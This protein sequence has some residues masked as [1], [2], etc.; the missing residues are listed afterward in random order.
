MTRLLSKGSVV[1]RSHY[2]VED[3]L[4]VRLRRL[5]YEIVGTN[6][7]PLLF[8]SSSLELIVMTETAGDG[9]L[10]LAAFTLRAPLRDEEGAPS[11]PDWDWGCWARVWEDEGKADVASWGS[12][13]KDELRDWDGIAEGW[14]HAGSSLITGWNSITVRILMIKTVCSYIILN[15]WGE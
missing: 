9:P 8:S 1:R 7:A 2:S 13:A 6:P 4:F 10:I 5:R 12:W 15:K 3:L 11:C 14:I